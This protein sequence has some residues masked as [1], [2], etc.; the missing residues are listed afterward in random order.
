MC[1]WQCLTRQPTQTQNLQQARNADG[2]RIHSIKPQHK[3]RNNLSVQQN[4][5]WTYLYAKGGRLCRH[6][7][8]DAVGALSTRERANHRN[9][10]RNEEIKSDN[11]LAKM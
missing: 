9:K 10:K 8:S 5:K 3:T 4:Y 1:L 2:M 7:F 6:N 11:R